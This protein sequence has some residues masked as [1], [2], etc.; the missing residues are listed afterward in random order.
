MPTSST[1][2]P[3][4]TSGATT[5]STASGPAPRDAEGVRR[6]PEGR[7]RLP[8]MPEARRLA[9]AGR[10]GEGRPLRGPAVLGA[11]GAGVRGPPGTR[12]RPRARTGRTRREPDGTDLHGRSFGGFPVRGAAPGRVREPAVVH[13]RGRRPPPPGGVPQRREPVRPTGEPPDPRGARP[14]PPVPRAGARRALPSPGDRSVGVVRLGRD[15]PG[16]HGFG[17]L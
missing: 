16:G 12:P 5:S 13:G 10:P 15:D 8:S 17:S 4:R 7:R 2:G 14:L 11:T 6:D 3:P 1:T 9:R